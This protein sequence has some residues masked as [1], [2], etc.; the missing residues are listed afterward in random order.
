MQVI[1]IPDKLMALEKVSMAT[2][3]LRSMEELKPEEWG[4]PPFDN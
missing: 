2:Q 3:V 4:L 1:G